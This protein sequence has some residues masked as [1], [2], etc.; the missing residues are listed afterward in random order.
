MLALPR[1]RRE[2]CVEVLHGVEV[3]DPYRWLEDG[4]SAETRAWVQAQTAFTRAV[5]DGLP[6]RA[7]IHAR[8]DEL[9]MTGAVTTPILRGTRRFYQRR[10]GRQDQPRLV[11]RDQPEGE[12]RTILDPNTLSA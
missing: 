4:E 10:D 7:A 2:A 1:T 6:Q 8:L 3:A 9:L 12:E 5:L 11:V